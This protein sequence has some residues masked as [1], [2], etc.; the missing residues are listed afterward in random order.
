M[1]SVKDATLSA[2]FNAVDARM[3]RVSVNSFLEMLVLATK[4]LDSF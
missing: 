1:L 2:E 4:T 3:L